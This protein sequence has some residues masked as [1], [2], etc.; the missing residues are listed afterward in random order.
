M[1]LAGRTLGG[2]KLADL[3][4]PGLEGSATAAGLHL[5]F[6]GVKWVDGSL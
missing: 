3:G 4:E 1:G 6:Q 2:Y 5:H